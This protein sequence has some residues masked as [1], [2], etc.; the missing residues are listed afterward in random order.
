MHSTTIGSRI[1]SFI[2][3]SSRSPSR[4]GGGTAGWRSRP[5]S[6]T[7][8][9][10]ASAAPRMAAA[11]SERSSSSQAASALS[12]AGSSVPG[13]RISAA[14]RRCC[15]SSPMS[16]P[17]ASPNSTSTRPSVAMTWS[18]GDSRVSSTRPS[19]EGPSMVPSSRKMATCGSPVRSTTPERSD[20]TI[21]TMPMSAST[22]VKLSWVMSSSMPRPWRRAP[23]SD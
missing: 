16:S 15:L 19:P 7:G 21:T 11:G 5:R 23:D 17:M 20:A 2:P 3:L 13:P 14:R 12:A 6:I 18:D 8:S 4:A 1:T 10:E 9:V 22:A